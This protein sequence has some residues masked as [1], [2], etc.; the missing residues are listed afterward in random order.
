MIKS[1]PSKIIA[2][3]PHILWTVE[4][5]GIFIVDQQTSKHFFLQYPG[6]AV[7]DLLNR[8]YSIKQIIP[9][10]SAIQQVTTGEAVQ[11]VQQCL[12]EW[13]QNGLIKIEENNG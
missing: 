5:G 3:L 13:Q 2:S 10:V 6:A 8:N 4:I 12:A 1:F 9:L 11:I 7:W